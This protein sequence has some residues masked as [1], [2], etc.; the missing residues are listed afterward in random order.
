MHE[1]IRELSGGWEVLAP[2]CSYRGVH[3]AASLLDTPSGNLPHTI[4]RPFRGSVCLCL[5]PKGSMFNLCTLLLSIFI[6][7]YSTI[8]FSDILLC[9]CRF[10]VCLFVFSF[11]RWVFYCV[12]WD[13]V[14]L[15]SPGWP[16]TC[17][18]DH[19]LRRLTFLCWIAFVTWQKPAG[20]ICVDLCFGWIDY[21]IYIISFDIR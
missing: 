13:R 4:I 14:S 1:E 21:Y 10:F 2:H 9:V 16:T 20:C 19:L 15:C 6:F 3:V 8:F 17:C 5:R 18:V 12:F 11:F 7:N